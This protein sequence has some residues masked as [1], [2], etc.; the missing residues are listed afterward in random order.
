M[1]VL[2]LNMS[3]SRVVGIKDID[4]D[5]H[6]STTTTNTCLC[7]SL[8][9][10]SGCLLYPSLTSLTRVKSIRYGLGRTKGNLH[11]KRD[12]DKFHNIIPLYI[13][14]SRCSMANVDVSCMPDGGSG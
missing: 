7:W 10:E 1:C 13:P 11:N 14:F 12:R 5:E 3:H 9:C 4:K 2:L 6:V 8:W